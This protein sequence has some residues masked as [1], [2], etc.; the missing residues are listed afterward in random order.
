MIDEWNGCYD[1]SWKGFIAEAAFAHPAKVARGL[2]AR[3][4]AHALRH[5]WIRPGFT[6]VDPFGGIGGTAL[7]A[8]INGVRWFGVELEPKFHALAEENFDLW[9][10]E[11][12]ADPAF[13]RPVM[14][15]GDSRRLC[16]VLGAGADAVVSSPPFSTPDCQ[17]ASVRQPGGRQ[18]VR[19]AYKKAGSDA[20]DSYG[21]TAGQLGAMKEG[22][23]DAAI[24]AIISSPPYIETNVGNN[25][26]ENEL[27]RIQQKLADGVP[28]GREITRCAAKGK[29][30][31]HEQSA[32]AGYGETAGQLGSLREGDVNAIVS[33]SPYEATNVVD[34]PRRAKDGA[35]GG[36]GKN[37]REGNR[38]RGAA[39]KE[40]GKHGESYGETAGQ[41]GQTEGETFWTAAAVIVS[42]CYRILRPGGV[43]IWVAK[44]Y[45]KRGAIVP[46]C[47]NWRRLC[48]HAGFVTLCQ[49]RAMLV[50]D[51]GDEL[52]LFG[53]KTRKIKE[54]KSFFRRLAEKRGS[55]PIDWEMVV[56]MQKPIGEDATP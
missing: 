12:R 35:A 2:A 9:A 13:V 19:S 21:T 36:I 38:P 44:D 39:R 17:P 54:R 31:P 30:S 26:A 37:F 43:A 41:M 34:L 27:R 14:R 10:R 52:N 53:P 28:L 33:S 15:L 23:I 55:P 7:Y 5:G 48:E 20:E 4:Y 6:V 42:Q 11:W 49:H 18:G 51:L 40:G 22:D 8:A 1:D 16:E 47:E 46:F 3:I 45:V 56:C 32:S 25:D 50:K 29:L 24:D